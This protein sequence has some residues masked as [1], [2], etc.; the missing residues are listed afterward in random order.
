MVTKITTHRRRRMNQDRAYQQRGKKDGAEEHTEEHTEDKK[1]TTTRGRGQ[2]MK[3][4]TLMTRGWKT[5]RIRTLKK[6][7]NKRR[8]L[9]ARWIAWHGNSGL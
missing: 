5:R 7:T 8:R 4:S 9:G 3:R 6:K 2:R 1:M